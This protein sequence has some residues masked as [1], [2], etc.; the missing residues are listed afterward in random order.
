MKQM[1]RILAV[2][3]SAVLLFG[4]AACGKTEVETKQNTASK[5]AATTTAKKKTL[6][7]YFSRAGENW[8]VGT[9]STGNTKLLAGMIKDSIGGDVFEI[10]PQVAY[11][12]SYDE[13]IEKATQERTDNARPT[14]KG[15]VKNWD[16]YDTV[17]LGYP[18]WWGD[19]PMILYTFL[20]NHDWTGKT[21]YPFSTNGGSGLADTVASI[22]EDAEGAVVKQGLAVEGKTV[23]NDK[24]GT[25]EKVDAWLTESGLR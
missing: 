18:I 22:R 14:Y 21:V 8:E 13:C 2:L 20:E 24:T 1:K 12:V 3:L 19:M 10:V 15:D 5:P 11:P 7:V 17:L 16:S 4:L 9:V 6:I 25:Q 23:R